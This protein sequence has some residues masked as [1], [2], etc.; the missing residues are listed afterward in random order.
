[1]VRLQTHFG[2]A[3]SNQALCECLCL[4]PHK[5]LRHILVVMRLRMHAVLSCSFGRA[6][7]TLAIAFHDVMAF[8]IA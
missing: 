4:C 7:N 8:A 2:H 3:L 1:M 6:I 5:L